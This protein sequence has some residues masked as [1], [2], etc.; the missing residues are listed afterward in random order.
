M[1]VM[2]EQERLEK[3]I[4]EI[5]EQSFLGPYLK[6]LTITD[7]R[8]N[9]TQLR[10]QD[11]EIGRYF[12][13]EQPSKEDVQKLVKQISDIQK[14]NFS[15]A[16]PQL[17]TEIGILRISGT[18]Q[19]ISIDGVN[20]AIRVSRPHL[21]ISSIAALVTGDHE[22]LEQ[23]F[24]VLMLAE[25]NLIICGR[26]GSGKTEFQKLLVGYTA[27]DANIVL[28]EDTRDSHIKTLYP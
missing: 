16:E 17:D 28:I 22:P 14:G 25:S 7:I 8:F 2:S 15:H 19:R 9:G 23:L 4:N 1:S 24:K 3:R 18:H 27:E 13:P 6:Q 11:N 20:L 10:I 5:L 12:P 26:T 21:A